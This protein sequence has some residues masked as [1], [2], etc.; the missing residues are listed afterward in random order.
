MDVSN[1]EKK[2]YFETQTLNDFRGI[3]VTVT[4]DDNSTEDITGDDIKKLNL[5]IE[6]F[7]A[8]KKWIA[9]A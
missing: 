6:P 3:V 1:A 5:Y 9:K 7:S 2:D 4:Y 8:D